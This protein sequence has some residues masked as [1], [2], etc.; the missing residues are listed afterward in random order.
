[1]KYFAVI[2]AA[3]VALSIAT[4]VELEARELQGGIIDM[5]INMLKSFICD[6]EEVVV[7]ERQMDIINMIINMVKSFLCTSQ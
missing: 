1:M 2:F 3:I 5:I 6:M 4:P 7:E